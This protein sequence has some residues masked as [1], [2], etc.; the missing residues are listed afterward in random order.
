MTIEKSPGKTSAFIKVEKLSWNMGSDPTDGLDVVAVVRN[1]GVDSIIFDQNLG[2]V[3]SL[4]ILG[5]SIPSSGKSSS[6]EPAS[7]KMLAE[8]RLVSD[9]GQLAPGAE[10]QFSGKLSFAHG[11]P[12]EFRCLL[13]LVESDDIWLPNGAGAFQVFDVQKNDASNFHSEIVD[14]EV[15]HAEQADDACGIIEM[16]IDRE[17]YLS[18]FEGA[19]IDNLAL[20]YA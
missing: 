20:H 17:Y 16:F 4:G 12:N 8:A 1:A 13:S 9:N 14:L 15:L 11:L 3:R 5:H 2:L 7:V 10:A 19:V 18:Q 6:V